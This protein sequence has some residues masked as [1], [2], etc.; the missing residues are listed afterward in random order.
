MTPEKIDRARWRKVCVAPASYYFVDQYEAL[1]HLCR[2]CM[3][4][5][6][7]VD[8]VHPRGRICPW[9]DEA[10]Q[11]DGMATVGVYEDA[12]GHRLLVCEHRREPRPRGPR[13]HRKARGQQALF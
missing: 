7:W 10:Q 6:G 12:D 5:R 8:V 4:E 13:G 1:D 9:M 11:A 3:M 2:G